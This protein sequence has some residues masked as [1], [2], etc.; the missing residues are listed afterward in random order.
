MPGEVEFVKMLSDFADETNTASFLRGNAYRYAR[1][2][3]IVHHVLSGYERSSIADIGAGMGW[4]SVLAKRTCP[5]CR[6]V[7]V[8]GER[9]EKVKDALRSEGVEIGADFF[10]RNGKKLPYD[11]EAFDVCLF[12]EVL[13]HCIEDPRHIIGELNRVLRKQ[14]TLVITT[15]NLASLQSRLMLMLGRQPQ[16]YLCNTQGPLGI[17]RGHFRTWTMEEMVMILEKGGF[18]IVEKRFVDFVGKGGLL[19]ERPGLRVL[20]GPYKW[21]TAV[22]PEFRTNLAIIAVKLGSA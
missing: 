14:G 10:F 5:S 16:P 18:K 9:S 17:G 21:T 13:E 2:Y 4:F 6:V 8:E 15:P 20:Y 12:L 22:F 7:S 19:A 3:D 11:D 1:T